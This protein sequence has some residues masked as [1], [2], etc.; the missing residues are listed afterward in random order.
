MLISAMLIKKT[1]SSPIE[2]ERLVMRKEFNFKTKRS[3]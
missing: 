3:E 2:S 1:C